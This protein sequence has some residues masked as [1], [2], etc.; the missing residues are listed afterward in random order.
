MLG[1]FAEEEG[2]EDGENDGDNVGV[3]DLGVSWLEKEGGFIVGV[4]G[5]CD[6][7]VTVENAGSPTITFGVLF[8]LVS[9]GVVNFVCVCVC[10]SLRLWD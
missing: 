9:V 4:C 8:S 3:H 5:W 1:R 2:G 6:V 10:V 7:G